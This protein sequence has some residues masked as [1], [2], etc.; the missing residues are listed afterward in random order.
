MKNFVLYIH[1]K[2]GSAAESGHYRPLFSGC[3][4]MGLDYHTFTPWETGEEIREA[5]KRL[6]NDYEDITL[7]ANS[8]GAYF[9]MNAGIGGLI[10]KA[11]VFISGLRRLEIKPFS[12]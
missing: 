5:V 9:C 6:K 2:G 11:Y 4:V 8:I 10:R 12:F 3:E 1:G 7:I